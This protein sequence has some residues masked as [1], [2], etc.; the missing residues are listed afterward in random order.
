MTV[1]LLCSRGFLRCRLA[2][3]QPVTAASQRTNAPLLSP[4]V[5]VEGWKLALALYLLFS[6]SCK[7]KPQALSPNLL[8]EAEAE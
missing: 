5:P 8:E 1:V 3:S 4:A 2:H 7:Q 6:F